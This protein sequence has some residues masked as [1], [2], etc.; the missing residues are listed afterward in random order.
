MRT[1]SRLA[2]ATLAA[3]VWILAGM[4]VAS[5]PLA[6]KAITPDGLDATVSC[7]EVAPS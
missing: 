1:A 4:S 7:S 6:S 5:G 2:A 3:A